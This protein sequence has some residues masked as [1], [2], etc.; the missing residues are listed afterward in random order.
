MSEDMKGKVAIVT[1]GGMG[2]GRA[3]CVAF[4]EKGVNVVVADINQ[5]AA[6]E[7]VKLVT[8]AGSKAVFVKCDVTNVDDIEASVAAAESHFGQLDYACNNAGIHP[9]TPPNPLRDLDDQIWDLAMEVNL[10]SVF[11]CMKK[12]LAAMEKHGSGAIVNVAS[13]AG[14]LAEPQSPAY[15]AS[16]HG[17]IGLTKAAALEY[18]PSGIRINAVCPSPVDTPMLEKAPQEF[19]N[20]LISM[21]P[22]GRFA[23]SEE[24]AGAVVW[25]CSDSASYINGIGLPVDGGV[26]TV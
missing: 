7:T 19:R 1:G 15:T 6:E 22:A 5:E 9:E 21:L 3:I 25:L 14:L 24:V 20:M 16:K 10:K 26:S 18:G 23:T 12:Q 4:A 8:D 13:L 17:V 11:R 2:I